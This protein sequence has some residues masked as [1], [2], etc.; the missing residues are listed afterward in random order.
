MNMNRREFLGR[1]LIGG[2]ALTGAGTLLQG[3]NNSGSKPSTQGATTA[4]SGGSKGPIRIGFIPLT[5][6]ASVVMA[7]ELGLYKKHG[8]EVEVVKQKNWAGTRDNLLSD[9][10]QLAHC[11]FG[12]P[13]SV[14]TGV[15]GPDVKGK[16][17][18]IAM[19]LNA[20]GQAITLKKSMAKKAGFKNLDGVKAAVAEMGTQPTFA[21]TYPGGTHDMW[22]RYWVDACG[23]DATK[24]SKD[25][26]FKVIPPP[27][28]V[29]NMKVNNMDGY[30]VGEP[31]GGVAVKDDIGYTHI[32]TQDIWKDHP[33][34]ALVCNEQFAVERRDDLRKVTM[35][36]MEASIWLDNMQNRAK[37]AK[38]V[39][40][41]KYVTAPSDV[42]DARLMGQYD[43]GAGLGKH[44]YKDDYML[45]HKSGDINFPRSSHAIWFMAQYMRFGMLP[46]AP[47]YKAVA[48]EI[49]MQDLY[50]EVAEE[51]KL[52][53]PDDDMKPFSLTIDKKIFDPSKPVVA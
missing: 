25:V 26:A 38:V 7:H 36:V 29:A 50:R 46:Q 24:T 40:G 48:D 49:L 27:Q 43:L 22:L 10:I 44:V 21:M 30:C 45:F 31:W 42:I 18:K 3:C 53:V 32:A 39:G 19:V 1:A 35:A 2:M 52:T 37:A 33:E 47:D 23:M 20:N 11:L 51:M 9:D 16:K 5:D 17:L 41:E 34:K 6:C 12:M 14:F 15:S 4:G 13:F 8:V 28:M